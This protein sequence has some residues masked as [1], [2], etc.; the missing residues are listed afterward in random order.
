MMENYKSIHY[1]EEVYI[2]HT[3]QKAFTKI[4]WYAI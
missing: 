1:I 4:Q 3:F 2:K